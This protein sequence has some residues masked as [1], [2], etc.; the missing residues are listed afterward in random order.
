MGAGELLYKRAYPLGWLDVPMIDT[1][2][3][4]VAAYQR[5]SRDDGRRHGRI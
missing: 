2:L 4:D 5:K 1:A 3:N